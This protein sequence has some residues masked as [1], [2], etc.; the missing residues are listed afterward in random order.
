MNE[1]FSAVKDPG[2]V[3]VAIA[4]L[5]GTVFAGWY[6]ARKAHQSQVALMAASQS[7]EE[8][9]RQRHFQ[10]SDR[11]DRL[12]V[13]EYIDQI[14]P[15]LCELSSIYFLAGTDINKD[16]EERRLFNRLKGFMNSLALD[17]AHPERTLSIRLAFL[18]FQVLAAMRLALNARWRRP[19]SAKQSQFL[20]HYETHL[21][22][23]LCSSRYPGDELLYR[24]QIEIITDSMLVEKEQGIVRPLN[25][26]EFAQAYFDDPV[27]KTLTDMVAAKFR[28]IFDDTNPKTTPI[29][30]ANQC[31][32]AI[33]A[34]YLIRMSTE[35]DS[36]GWS[37]REEDI[38]RVCVSWFQWEQDQKQSPQWSVFERGDVA[39]RATSSSRLIESAD[40][41]LDLA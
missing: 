33:L 17:H 36:L 29:R 39:R 11:A 37:R 31:R 22:P 5:F 10:E 27:I 18:L 41:V 28:F 3:L 23:I 40:G 25:W 24:E 9:L 2:T 12:L 38:W 26:R 4:G 13:L 34:L 15:R 20:A 32:L 35:A 21:E 6:A 14:L 7:R 30:R 19:L 8:E 1:F 16:D